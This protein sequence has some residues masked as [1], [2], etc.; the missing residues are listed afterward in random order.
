LAEASK[1]SEKKD[2][3]SKGGKQNWSLG[4]GVRKG[5]LRECHRHVKEFCLIP[6]VGEMSLIGVNYCSDTIRFEFYKIT[7][8]QRRE[9]F[10]NTCMVS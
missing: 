8:T 7:L 3:C 9:Q 2:H 10:V 4:Y 6:I 1:Y 5:N